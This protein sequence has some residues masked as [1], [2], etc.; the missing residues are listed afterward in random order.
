M[1]SNED[2]IAQKILR[3]V[4]IAKMT[5][6]L[7]DRLSKAGLKV[8]G[9]QNQSQGNTDQALY[10]PPSNSSSPLSSPSKSLS[11][12]VTNNITATAISNIQ[13]SK[14]VTPTR[15]TFNFDPTLS[16]S[17]LTPIIS[18]LKRKNSSIHRSGTYSQSRTSIYESFDDTLVSPMKRMNHGPGSSTG[19]M[20]QSSPFP[21]STSP[22][23][24]SRGYFIQTPQSL[25]QPVSLTMSMPLSQPNMNAPTTP[26][27]KS[28][29]LYPTADTSDS[30]HQFTAT[31][32][33]GN[34][35]SNAGAKS[36]PRRRAK[37]ALALKPID[38][39]IDNNNVLLEKACASKSAHMDTNSDVSNKEQ[40]QT[41]LLSTPKAP[42]I[43][44][45][46]TPNRPSTTGGG[47][48]I[49][50]EDVGADLLLFLSN[51]PARNFT[52]ARGSDAHDDLDATQ[53]PSS[54]SITTS[55]VA[56][57]NTSHKLAIP[58]TPKASSSSTM[59][60]HASLLDS[61]PMRTQLPQYFTSPMLMT[62]N[63]GINTGTNTG[64]PSTSLMQP[65]LGTPIRYAPA[66]PKQGGA[67]GFGSR[68]P[69]FSMSDYIN[70]TPSPRV[71]RT[72]DYHGYGRTFGMIPSVRED[73]E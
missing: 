13:N 21:N 11:E 70:F 26:P 49:G 71:G 29:D 28:T 15:T 50:N 48:G 27:Q 60:A 72:P 24:Y 25:S 66:T 8:R 2:I 35:N 39:E 64:T 68:T 42:R 7:K 57:S 43:K 59:G 31:R 62:A 9:D 32:G 65:L 46:T 30:V 45:F 73:E 53:A 38:N 69:G 52:P 1:L 10:R 33:K 12:D 37:K 16:I 41:S 18:P 17:V 3:R 55:T 51:S 22:Y 47:N 6:Q 4:E 61:T 34:G 14:L 20:L 58:T 40:I 63:S 54:S 23:Q 67:K 5:R 19:S 44:E 36:K 56:V